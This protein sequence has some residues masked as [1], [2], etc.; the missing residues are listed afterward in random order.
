MKADQCFTR[1]MKMMVAFGESAQSA[2][3]H[4]WDDRAFFYAGYIAALTEAKRPEAY[5]V[6]C[7]YEET[8]K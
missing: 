2:S 7:E 4:K 1:A 8:L 3:E 6:L 5:R